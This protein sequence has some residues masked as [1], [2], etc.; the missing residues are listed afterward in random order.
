MSLQLRFNNSVYQLEAPSNARGSMHHNAVVVDQL[1]AHTFKLRIGI[2]GAQPNN[3]AVMKLASTFDE[4][5]ALEL[6]AT[7]YQ[8]ELKQLQGTYVPTFFGIFHGEVLGEL[9]ACMIL[10]YCG[11]GN[12]SMDERNR[13]VMLAACAIHNAGVMHCD[14]LDP[15]HVL[16]S[17]NDVRVV[18]FSRAMPHRCYGATPTLYPGMGGDSDG[19]RELLALEASYGVRS[20]ASFPAP[21]PSLNILTRR[22]FGGQR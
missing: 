12:I 22:F 20:G 14:L 4:V 6:E 1:S 2:L 21:A 10:E 11:G 17:G 5:R 18:D 13:K 8:S 3:H 16:I 9:G 19:C 15:S 7:L